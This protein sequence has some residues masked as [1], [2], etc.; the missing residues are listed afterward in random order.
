VEKKIWKKLEFDCDEADYFVGIVL[1]SN[2]GLSS[3]PPLNILL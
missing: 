1:V 2:S 3:G